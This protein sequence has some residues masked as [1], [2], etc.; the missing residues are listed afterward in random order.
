MLS[1]KDFQSFKV[2]NV[3]NVKGKG[4]PTGHTSGSDEI[5]TD[6]GD[7][8]MEVNGQFAGCGCGGSSFSI[9]CCNQQ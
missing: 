5:F 7:S 4:T 9:A 1:L 8:Y 6:S 2:D 3:Y